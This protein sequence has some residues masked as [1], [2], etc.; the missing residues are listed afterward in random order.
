MWPA[1]CPDIA[2]PDLY[3]FDYLKG[4]VYKD[5]LQD[6]EDL[7]H[8][9]LYHLSR[10]QQATMTTVFQN[11]IKNVQLPVSAVRGSHFQHLPL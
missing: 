2:P 9:I 4:K 5:A 1:R 6:L 8:R 3:L 10:I 11:L 7:E